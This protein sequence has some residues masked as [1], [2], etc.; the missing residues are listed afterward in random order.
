MTEDQTVT[1]Y[2]IELISGDGIGP[3]VVDV[4]LPL[5]EDVAD[6][7]G[8]E[9][10]ITRRD[11]ESE[12]YLEH[13]KM[14]L[15]DVLSELADADSIFIGAVGHPE[16]PDH[17]T[18]H[19]LLLPIGKGLDRCVCKRPN[20]LLES[21]E[22]LL[23]GHEAGE[24]EFAVCRENTEAEYAD[25]GGREHRP[26]EPFRRHLDRHWCPNHR[27]YQSITLR[28]PLSPMADAGSVVSV[29]I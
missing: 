25:I 14:M 17:V 1:T 27:E 23:N 11:W 20:V 3:E 13:G 19:G 26:L 2:D 16:L 4:A 28:G 29:T 24:I 22:S 7:Y 15:E 6:N 8:F 12:H 9:L 21:I 18:L 10:D 5:S